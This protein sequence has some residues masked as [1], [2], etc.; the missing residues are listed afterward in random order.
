MNDLSA[1]V[2]NF[3]MSVALQNRSFA[4]TDVV[5]QLTV[6]VHSLRPDNADNHALANE[7][8]IHL[9]ETLET[10]DEA[11]NALRRRLLALLLGRRQVSFF[12]DTGILPGTGFFSELWRRLTQ[13]VLP[14]ISDPTYLKDC[15]N[16]IFHRHDDYVWLA[17]IS[18][19]LKM[20]FWQALRMSE[21]RNEPILLDTL[22]QMLDAGDNLAARIGAMGLDPELVRLYPRIEE[23]DSPFLAL[24]VEAHQLAASYRRYLS[25]GESSVEDEKQLLV[26]IAQCREAMVRIRSRAASIGTSLSVTYLMQRLDQSLSRLEALVRILSTRHEITR[27]EAED[28]PL[29]ELWVNFL[30][31]ALEGEARR[32]GIRSLIGRTIGL[33]ALRITHNASRTGEHY[34]TTSRAEYMEMWRSASGAGFIIGFMALIKLY[35]SMAA[36]SPLG[37]AL[38]YSLDYVAGFILVHIAHFTIATKQP[39]M[40]AS[41]IAGAISE[42]RG[43]VRDVEKLAVLVTDVI[44]SQIAAILGNVLIALPTAMLLAFAVAQ[45]TGEP[46]LDAGKA[47]ALL[48]F[49]S[50]FDSLALFYAAI[51]G[52][53]LFLAGLISGYYDNLA[54]YERIRERVESTVWLKTLLGE[55]A[56]SR[57]ARYLDDNLGALAGNFFFGI[58]LGS[59]GTIGFIT[60][61]PL[62]VCHVTFSAA[63]FGFAMVSLNFSPDLATIAA[64]LA[65]VALIG[66]VNLSVSFTLALWVALRAR[67]VGFDQL[68]PL[69]VILLGRVRSDWKRF[70]WP[71]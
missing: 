25:G 50:P 37:Y 1:G 42:I 16:R 46:F 48:H 11:R 12:A 64:S 62:E 44:R 23:R 57:L 18:A 49:I 31:D 26:L 68:G 60:G 4:N 66:L 22:S 71:T 14:A 51:A 61:L 54:A 56:R 35:L 38:M 29:V 69:L 63:Y 7:R 13:R 27:T 10:N 39:A 17:G 21:L 6:L 9:C 28:L 30:N 32:R 45:A 43:R 34:I 19:Q 8:F 67:G 5:E 58:M 20:R 59:M 41:T 2:T 47:A 40:T 24:A 70:V 55:N 3:N 52:C 15:V 36:L 53:C 33:L 65:G